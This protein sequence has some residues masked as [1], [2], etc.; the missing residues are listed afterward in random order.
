M[1]DVFIQPPAGASLATSATVGTGDTDRGLALRPR[2]AVV[3]PRTE[4]C[5]M[6]Y[7]CHTFTRPSVK[8][9]V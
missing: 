2:A 3:S 1:T 8:D 4:A 5:L 9:R 6:I 7:V